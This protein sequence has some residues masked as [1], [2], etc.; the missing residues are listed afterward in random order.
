MTMFQFMQNAFFL[1]CGVACVA[2]AF[3]I[4][5]VTLITIFRTF[6]GE[7]RNGRNKN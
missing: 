7:K 2:V 4:I 3:L 6:K 5:Y 1:L